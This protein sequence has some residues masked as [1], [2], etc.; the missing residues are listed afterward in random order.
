MNTAVQSPT[1]NTYHFDPEIE[2]A[3]TELVKNDDTTP[4]PARGDW[5]ALRETGNA[6]H[7]YWASQ[8]PSYPDVHTTDFTAMAPDGASID[9]RWYT[10]GLD[11][12]GSAVVYVH[13]GGMVLSSL[14]LYDP[15]VKEYASLTGVPFLALNYRLAPEAK[16]KTLAEDAFAGF[17]WLIQNAALLGIDPERIAIMGD[18]GGGAPAA[19]VAI[20]ARDRQIPLAHQILIYPMLDDRN[21]CPDPMLLPFLTWTYD[22]NY[23]AWTA[24]L[25]SEAGTD[26]VS[27]IVAPAR[28]K[29]FT[30][31]APAYIEVGELDI[32]RDEDLTY[33]QQL[34]KAG[35]PVE[36]HLHSGAPHGYDRIATGSKLTQRAMKDRIRVIQSI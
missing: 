29:D 24:V 10:K 27:P 36:L 13:G 20:M 2:V 34:T 16:G 26:T 7:A 1:K 28:L 22:N 18:S 30:G 15:V 23:T 11:M 31:L 14:D 21:L 33:A 25:G 32:F 19:G 8:A 6:M 17:S 35:V 12:P 9:L 5:K 3:I 4:R